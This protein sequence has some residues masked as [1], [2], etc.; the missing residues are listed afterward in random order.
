MFYSSNHTW[1]F[2]ET[3]GIAR[4]G[5][6][7]LLAHLTGKVEIEFLKAPGEEVRKGEVFARVLQEGKNLEIQSPLSGKAMSLNTALAFEPE[8]FNEDP[9]NDGWVFRIE[10]D[11][12]KAETGSC[13]MADE[14]RQWIQQEMERFR[15]FVVIK[16]HQYG[17]ASSPVVLQDGG[18]LKEHTLD[19]LPAEIWSDF[20]DE[21]LRL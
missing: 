3:N 21:F 6:D 10:P 12:W 16:T 9:Y 4:V 11:N 13:Y 15:E 19:A 14:A 8:L 5:M 7:D 18:E 1:A 20:Q 2:L 17:D